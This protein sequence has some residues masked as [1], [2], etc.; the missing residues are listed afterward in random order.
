MAHPQPRGKF[1]ILSCFYGGLVV[2][3][4]RP[5]RR[6]LIVEPDPTYRDLLQRLAQPLAKVEAAGDF[7]SAYSR[8]M[9][10]PPD[11]LITKL[12]L[13]SKTEGLELASALASFGSPTRSIVYGD[14]A[15]E[16]VTR[17]LQRLGAF[18]EAQSRLQFAL[19]AYVQATLPVLDRRDPM[20]RER[21]MRYRGG[22]RASDVPLISAWG[23]DDSG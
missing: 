23:G 22:R 7:R 21:R 1:E 16:W 3:S 11:V 14:S 8:L 5:L 20:R 18:Y 17:E 9:P 15:E 2:P 13:Q 6:L 4:A 10:A 19:A 12:R